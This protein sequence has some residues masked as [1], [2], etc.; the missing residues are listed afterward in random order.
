MSPLSLSTINDGLD[1]EISNPGSS[2]FSQE[3]QDNP[4]IGVN[5]WLTHFEWQVD[6]DLATLL[7]PP[8]NRTRD[9]MRLFSEF[10]QKLLQ[11]RNNPIWRGKPQRIKLIR[12]KRVSAILHLEE[13]FVTQ[14]DEDIIRKRHFTHLDP[15]KLYLQLV[16]RVLEPRLINQANFGLCGPATIAI[17][18]AKVDPV[19]YVNF[20]ID[21][22]KNGR[23]TIGKWDCEP[24]EMLRAYSDVDG[25][26][27]ICSA[28]WL[29]LASLR[30][31]F[32][33]WT[34]TKGF[35]TDYWAL[36]EMLQK[37]GFTRSYG[38]QVKKDRDEKRTIGFYGA[39][40]DS[41]REALK[42]LPYTEG[43]A[44]DFNAMNSHIV[45][46]NQAIADDCKVIMFSNRLARANSTPGLHW[47]L[48]SE[49]IKFLPVGQGGLHVSFKTTEWGKKHEP[50][51]KDLLMANLCG[52]YRGFIACKI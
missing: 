15:T 45:A 24:S 32:Q 4:I 1:N 3:L 13:A 44:P 6:R 7:N 47:Y 29:V 30:N 11:I 46:I 21:L 48:L 52:G 50:K 42:H 18:Q 9:V 5:T 14:P 12:F 51:V 27:T 49:G 8:S 41:D 33:P 17:L 26:N 39:M 2:G 36:F 19:T 37:S 31:R 34:T 20:A 28:D 35:G 10:A 25:P 22:L 38:V 43:G 40:S 16:L 23:A